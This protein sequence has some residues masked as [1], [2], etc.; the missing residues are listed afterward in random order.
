MDRSSPG[1]DA[2]PFRSYWCYTCRIHWRLPARRRYVSS[3]IGQFVRTARCYLLHRSFD[4]D[5]AERQGDRFE[6][7]KP[8]DWLVAVVTRVVPIARPTC[9]PALPIWAMS[10]TFPTITSGPATRS[11]ASGPTVCRIAGMTIE[12]VL[13]LT[14]SSISIG[15]IAAPTEIF[16][17]ISPASRRSAE[18]VGKLF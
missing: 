11:G 2:S 4:K 8:V 9:V 18:R 15:C 5:F 14:S 10:W 16:P 6:A 17:T 1:R 12:L 13:P 3:R 7:T